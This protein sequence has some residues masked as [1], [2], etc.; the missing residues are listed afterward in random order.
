MTYPLPN[1]ST[2][3]TGRVALVTGASSGLGLRFAKVLASCGAKVAVAARRL[4]RLES[5]AAEIRAAGGEAVAIAMDATDSDQLIAA[6]AQAEA[7]FGTVDILINN[8]GIPDAQRATKMTTEL[9]DAVLDTNLRGPYLLACEVARRLIDAK[10]PGRMVNISSMGAFSYS[11]QGAALYSIT[12]A[13]ID[14]MTET[15]AVEWARFNINVNSIAPGAFARRAEKLLRRATVGRARALGA[16]R[17]VKDSA[18]AGTPPP[19]ASQIRAMAL[20]ASAA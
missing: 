3:L 1:V 8:A 5:L 4:D 16:V 11:G 6:V 2:D 18:N 15:L 9:I 12:K 10:T 13:A 20:A 7:A 19:R 14:R 17:V